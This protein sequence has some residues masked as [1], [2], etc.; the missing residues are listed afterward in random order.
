MPIDF[1]RVR[2]VFEA[3]VE[4]APAERATK[5][6]Q[7]C[8]TDAELRRR[9]EA[10][11]KAHDDAGELPTA[12][13]FLEA[14]AA[15][16]V[17]TMAEPVS[18]RPGTI[19]GTYK[20]LEQIGEGGFGVVFMAEQTRPVRRKVAL[21][22]LKPGMDSRQVIARFEAE[23]Q[24]L[25]IMD[26][27]NIA[28]VYDGGV[29]PSG[30]PYFV[31]EL[32]KGVPVTDFCDQ[33]HLTPR[34]RLELFASACQAVQH[35]H[36]K[37][38]IH[39]D[40]KPSN[41]LV[42]M[43]DGTPLVKIIDFGVAKALGQELTDKTLFTGFAQMIGTPLY[44]SREQAG[45]SLDIDTRTDI[46]SLGVVLY[47]LLTGSTPF[48]KKRFQQ[49]AY[50]EIRRIIR[51]EE[52]PKPS[53]RLS[54][55]KDSLASI[56][57]QRHTEP[58]KLTKLVRGELDWIVMKALEKDRRR[59]YETASALAADVHRYLAD[60]TVQA[61]PPSAW[62]RWRKFT[63]RHRPAVVLALASVVAALALVGVA[64]A[65]AYNTRLQQEVISTN[66]ARQD[67]ETHHRRAL[68]ALVEA[69]KLRYF[70]DIARAHAE[71]RGG[72]MA[73]VEPLLD[74]CPAQR[75][76]WEW[77]YL[78]RLCHLDLRTL[79]EGNPSEHAGCQIGFHPN[80]KWLAAPAP[81]G[82][83]LLWDVDT[84][85]EVRKF[86]GR[87]PR[88]G[89]VTLSPDGSRLAGLALN[90]LTVIIWDVATGRETHRLQCDDAVWGT[91]RLMF[92]PDS[93][94]LAC[95]GGRDFVYVWNV[96]TGEE[97]FRVAPGSGGVAYSPDGSQL[98]TGSANGI[99]RL[100]NA[101]T[102]GLSRTL[103]GE[104]GWV[105]NVAFSP[106]GS[107]L[108]SACGGDRTVKIWDR[109]SGRKLKTL[110]G[111]AGGVY[112]VAWSPDGRRLASGS[113]DQTVR[114]WETTTGEAVLVF[115]GHASGVPGVTFGPHG[116]TL[117]S[118]SEYQAVKL[119]DTRTAPEVRT[120]AGHTGNVRGAAFSPDGKLLVSGAWD[121]TVKIWDTTSGRELRTL[122]GHTGLV[123]CVAFSPD[124][125][126]VASGGTDQV[127][128]MWDPASGREVRT[129]SGHKGSVEGVAFSPD[130]KWL[131]S[132]SGDRSIKIWQA[133]TGREV[134]T[135]SGHTDIVQAVAF[136][137][138]GTQ[139]VSGSHDGTLR[140]W[141]AM[142]GKEMS[143]L[144]GRQGRVWSVAFSPDGARLASGHWSGNII[145]WDAAAGRQIRTLVGHTGN[146]LGVAFSP[147]GSRLASAS[148]DGTIKL[149][150]TA[151]GQ[152][153]L[154]L[155][156]HTDEVVSVAFSPD[157][158]WLASTSGDRTVKLWDGRPWTA[159]K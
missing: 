108:A 33:D 50:D 31:M 8:G 75:R 95:A 67:A 16:L 131:A 2:S 83:V 113:F 39:R 78:K 99:V 73:L 14:P 48:A 61:C 28:K 20:L 56:S 127:V 17:A 88:I 121:Q 25:A 60:E 128:K 92:S 147:D 107:R 49:A 146:V 89:P 74:G 118:I 22:V 55:S 79:Q 157:G 81:G 104:G 103:S 68:A 150:D 142:T 19:I 116:D 63:R 59:R 69:E 132:A 155:N 43:Q 10:L 76:N 98:A 114:L 139:L 44:M 105:F 80:G 102:G 136:S 135:F 86:E 13:S 156:G 119:W 97:C 38:I 30:R 158:G 36:Q 82:T 21:K 77:H 133:T 144:T 52:P 7:A 126:C 26:H 111:H 27:P 159:G 124:G 71:Y 110:K 57:A 58:A 34:E 46:Y 64:V 134:R 101:T 90:G 35:A 154:T 18:E 120:L 115:R 45:Q 138:D 151:S 47:E 51:E 94:R 123:L 117:A 106:D 41:V 72:N 24:A 11:L 1:K 37:G 66:Q 93:K 15:G 96:A 109:A 3:V 65:L 130:G 152:E 29:T 112:D 62:Y 153:L 143:T 40:L 87:V 9:V 145:V 149:W 12:S 100:W 54:E 6:E 5:L 42:A 4:L 32:V 140:I 85:K 84:G 122:K 53:T 70:L 125:A 137:P 23:R 141:D 129:L 148:Y 91:P